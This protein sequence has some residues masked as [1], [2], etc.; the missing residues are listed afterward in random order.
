MPGADREARF[1]Q[2]REAT[3]REVAA[4]RER[5]RLR[6]EQLRADPAKEKYVVL[7]ERGQD[8][9]DDQ[10]AYHEDVHRTA[11][12]VHLQ[13]IESA[14]RLS[15]IVPKLLVAWQENYKSLPQIKANCCIHIAELQRQFPLA[16]SVRYTEDYAPERYH[17][18]NPWAELR[19]TACNS[20]IHLEHSAHPLLTTK[21]FPPTPD[22]HS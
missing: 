17:Q 6:I 21:W 14:M 12:C 2:L 18:D 8:W 20:I 9:S 16:E 22:V 15:G 19:C 1:Q 13:A 4:F 10:I 3:A 7:V 11:T 5:K